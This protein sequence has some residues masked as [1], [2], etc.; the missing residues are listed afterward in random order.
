MSGN[1]TL[2]RLEA[3]LNH[4]ID[5]MLTRRS[6][7]ID[8]LIGLNHL[9]DI[10]LDLAEKHSVTESLP[11]FLSQHQHW[12]ANGYLDINQKNRLGQFLS[13]LIEGLINREDN[14][15]FKLAGEIKEWSHRLGTGSYHFALRSSGE[16]VPLADRYN[17][18][19]KREAEEMDI[20]LS[21]REHLLTC[22]DDILFMAENREDKMYQHMAASLIYFLKTEGYRV[23]PYIKRLRKV[24]EKS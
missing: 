20:L 22:L 23:D 11:Q 7:Q 16:Q 21:E 13:P 5:G 2:D 6:Y 14:E 18:L 1:K 9:D 17:S 12:L 10:L 24:Q 3:R 19:L 15:H 8:F 4:L